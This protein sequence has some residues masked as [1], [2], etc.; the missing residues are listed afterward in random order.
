MVFGE[1]SAPIVF[2]WIVSGHQIGAACAASLAGV[3]RQTQGNYEG[4]LILAGI[5]GVIAAFI[6]IAIQYP[7]LQMEMVK[8]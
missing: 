8:N 5:I 7:K 6:S 2:G 1:R 4:I 3:L